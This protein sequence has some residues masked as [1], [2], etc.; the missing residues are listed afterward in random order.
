M[1]TP[2]LSL[3][4][5]VRD[6]AQLLAS[7]LAAR[8]VADECIVVDTGST[9]GTP[10]IARDLGARV[11]HH[12]WTGSLGE[13]RNRYLAEA[14]GRWVLV[15]DGDERLAPRD[16]PRIRPLLATTDT[17]AYRVTVHDYTRTIDLL[18]DWHPNSGA[19][20]E[21]EAASGCPGH[22]RFAVVRLFRRAPGVRYEEGYSTH[23]NPV[24]SLRA[25]G[26]AIR[27]A[28]VV[29][30]HFQILKGGEPFV[31]AKQAARLSWELRHLEQAPDHFLAN[32]NV[33]RTLFAL[34]RDEEAIAHLDRA[35][36]LDPRAE[37]AYLVRGMVRF[38]RREL[39][40]AARDLEAATTLR[41]G[42][43]DAWT[44]LGMVYHGLGRIDG[45]ERA[46]RTALRRRPHHPL[47]I[48]SLGVLYMDL[49][50]LDEA[51]E[52]FE[53]ALRILP[54]HPA[55]SA[56]LGDLRAQRGVTS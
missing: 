9:D 8:D 5:V 42:F 41:P 26:G 2:L 55:A 37:Q 44:V 45:A 11:V 40:Q 24:A 1:A 54:D 56:N 31:R 51:E 30:H 33:G 18:R 34:G 20:A 43:A 21:E 22:A 53:R 50:R 39:E 35:L 28:D 16:L 32:L 48:N 15:L 10:E 4:L 12:P 7:A 47:A 36:A 23:T 19:Y 17:V 29:V 13:A 3:C 38:E 46:L 52:Q 27:D 6:E 14:R 25:L 49:G